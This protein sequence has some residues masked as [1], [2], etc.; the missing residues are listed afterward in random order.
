M[1]L[2]YTSLTSSSG[3]LN[4]NSAHLN[5]A[6]Q[7]SYVRFVDK[8][9]DTLHFTFGPSQQ[10]TN[11]VASS[12]VVQAPNFQ[13]VNIASSN[14]V[15]TTDATGA[16][17]VRGGLTYDGATLNIDGDVAVAGNLN[18]VG[19]LT[20]VDT[21]T[22]LIE[23]P[24]VQIGANNIVDTQD[25]GFILT[26][27]SSNLATNVAVGYSPTLNGGEFVI[28]QTLSS[29]ESGSQA[30]LNPMTE[31][32]VNVHVYG[33]LIANYLHGDGSNLTGITGGSSSSN[34]QTVMNNGA[35]SDVA[36]VLT[37]SGTAID[38]PTGTINAYSIVGH[39]LTGVY[40]AAVNTLN[41]NEAHITNVYVNGSTTFN[42][43][44]VDEV[45][46][47]GTLR[48]SGIGFRAQVSNVLGFDPVT[49][50]VFNT[51]LPAGADSTLDQVLTN[52]KT[53]A[54]AI[55]FTGASAFTTTGS[56]AINGTVLSTDGSNNFH[57][58]ALG[59][60]LVV[61]GTTAALHLN[62]SATQIGLDADSGS[63]KVSA[64]SNVNLY[65]GGSSTAAVSVKANGDTE[66]AGNL[67]VSGNIV[68]HTLTGVYSGSINTLNTNN[69]QNTDLVNSGLARF[70]ANVNVDN[71]VFANEVTSN[72]VTAP[73]ARLGTAI[74]DSLDVSGS[75]TISGVTTV[76]VLKFTPGGIDPA[77]TATFTGFSAGKLNVTATGV[78]YGSATIDS[79]SGTVTG[80]NVTGLADNAHLYLYVKGSQTFA[81]PTD[82]YTYLS[83]V[84]GQ[85]KVM[86]HVF[87][88]GGTVFVDM[89]KVN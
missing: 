4:V 84:T 61:D 69:I 66:M 85:Y 15:V 49:R 42:G 16:L 22:I 53:T 71:T 17:V 10:T 73:L 59:K 83:A 56:A 24:I 62:S 25:V 48:L 60:K 77:A 68:G 23:D 88:V 3:L 40:S 89:T 33:T 47:S 2:T 58:N 28:A 44:I 26:A 76:S 9:S 86:Y 8:F 72:V 37:S 36:M 38:C 11:V 43:P 5:L 41:A 18:V 67:S 46:M 7:G 63:V 70:R 78:T 35:T 12:A 29:S 1:S 74:T 31:G 14:G 45:E 30:V 21:Q 65:P 39:T 32:S 52:G 57:V 34:L 6:S 50:E 79:V 27:N 19:T 81:T 64:A 87:N 75:A 54:Q 82:G 20:V 51:D 55:S 80:L 13:A